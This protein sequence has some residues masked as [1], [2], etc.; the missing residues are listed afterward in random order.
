MKNNILF[1]TLRVFGATGGIE[2]V[3][4][5]AGKSIFEMTLPG[6]STAKIFCMHD[7]QVD[8]DGNKYFPT[9]I[10]RGFGGAKIKFLYSVI[11]KCR[12]YDTVILSHINLISIGWLI[13]KVSPGTKIVMFAHGIEVWG[14]MSDRK[15]KLMKCCDHIIPVSHFTSTKMQELHHFP[16]T[17]CTVLNNCMDP[18]LP[19]IPG[20]NETKRLRA[21][22]GYKET[23]KLLFTLSRLSS[24]EKY[25]G[26]DKVM[27]AM[28]L[29]KEK[30][31]GIRYLL[32]GGYDKEEKKYVEALAEKLG[33][34][35]DVKIT[36]FIPEEDLAAHFSIADVY[37]MPSLQ[38]GFGIV[39][40]EAMYYG[41]PVIAGNRDGSVD[42]LC[43]GR[44]GIL[45]DP[46]DVI[47]I[48]DSIE[49][50]LANRN[51]FVPNR[52]LLME[53]FD[54]ENYKKKLETIL[55]KVRA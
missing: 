20:E 29:L 41:I 12:A 21:A 33:L 51:A 25:K 32:A 19:A 38:E 36:G 18:F 54:Y 10:F 50:V 34:K 3:C 30:F 4:R 42:A 5:V 9:Q 40:I 23:D 43:N 8:A 46:L 2:K 44:L 37:V 49:K 15:K 6:S 27:E 52:E 11:K 28:P 31:P 45:A 26:Y 48:G 47:A 22:Y 16:A 53:A 24:Q 39:F 55:E 35:D 13:K 14:M 17:K 7:H 1:L